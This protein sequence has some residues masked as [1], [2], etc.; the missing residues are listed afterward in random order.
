MAIENNGQNPVVPKAPEAPK[1]ANKLTGKAQEVFADLLGINKPPSGSPTGAGSKPAMNSLGDI[2]GVPAAQGQVTP[3]QTKPASKPVVLD[4][5]IEPVVSKLM[6]PKK[7]KPGAIMLKVSFAVLILV[8][9]FFFTQNSSRFKLLGA[10]A[11]IKVDQAYEQV[12][13]L[14]AEIIVQKH[15]NTVMLLEKF[16][17]A[18][19]QYLYYSGEVESTYTSENKKTEYEAEVEKLEPELLEILNEIKEN[20]GTPLTD[21]EK[22]AGVAEADAQ[23]AELKSKE[24][25]VDE[26]S[27]LNDV[28]DMETTRKLILNT[29]FKQLFTSLNFENDKDGGENLSSA[30]VEY[31][32]DEYSQVNKSVVSLISAI[33]NARTKWSQYIDEVES[34]TKTVDPLFNTE[35]ESNLSID[36]VSFA[37]ADS[38]VGVSGS[39]DTDDSKNF[40]L[41]AN[42]VDALEESSLFTD[43]SERSYSKNSSGSSE[44]AEEESEE[45]FSSSF[46]I[47]MTLESNETEND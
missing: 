12:D 9:G 7:S 17:E 8:G 29:D 15:L 6:I 13:T 32:F 33:K 38:S 23:I 11:A 18:A 37:S 34:V 40:T 31:I 25:Q 30:S 10:N 5:K 14:N 47:D 46:Q 21:E 20:I 26:Q 36:T 16:S 19:D 3:N 39:T 27:L 41:V 22:N 28:Q 42:F 45:T 24:G 35:F 2:A 1:D 44:S 43:A 4:K